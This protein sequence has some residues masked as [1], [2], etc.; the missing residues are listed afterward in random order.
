MKNNRNRLFSNGLFYIVVFLLLLWGINWVLGG[1]SNSGATETISYS[2]FVKKLRNGEIKDFNV[3][4]SNGVYSVT[5]SYK[6]SQT[7]SSSSSDIFGGNTSSKVTG[8][9]TTMLEND[10]SVK[11][12]QDLAQSENVKMST[13]G[14]SQ[15][16]NWI[17][18]IIMLVPTVL[19]IVLMVMMMNQGGSRGQAGSRVVVGGCELS[20]GFGVS[21][22]FPRFADPGY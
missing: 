6:S 18:T 15:S 20:T 12:V 17:S 21:P 16:S 10:P 13:Q 1:S 4:P 22:C 9:S 8:F 19:F 14:E 7:K 11:K 3:Q 5:G 2:E